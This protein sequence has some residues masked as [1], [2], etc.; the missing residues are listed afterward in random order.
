[1]RV[2]SVHYFRFTLVITCAY[3]GYTCVRSTCSDLMCILRHLVSL[4]PILPLLRCYLYPI[5]HRY[6]LCIASDCRLSSVVFF[7]LFSMPIIALLA[8][9]ITGR[10]LRQRQ[11]VRHLTQ[12]GSYQVPGAFLQLLR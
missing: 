1:M 11:Y 6:L 2:T 10:S 4:T 5:P 12:H 9:F 3:S 8:G 7:D